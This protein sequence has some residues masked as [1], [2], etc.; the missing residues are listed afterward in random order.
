MNHI[1]WWS[2]LHIRLLFVTMP[3]YVHLSFSP[4]NGWLD[5]HFESVLLSKLLLFSLFLYIVC[6]DMIPSF[7]VLILLL[8]FGMLCEHANK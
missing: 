7:L 2:M 5:S 1:L 4:H 6:V 3:I 8:S